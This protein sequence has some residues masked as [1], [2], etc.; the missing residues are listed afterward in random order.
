MRTLLII[1]AGISAFIG[2]IITILPFGTIGILPG[3]GAILLGL[4]AYL[5]SKKKQQPHKLSLVF[6]A[7][8]VLVTI[9]SGTKTLWVKDEIAVDKTFEKKEEQHKKEAIKELNELESE[10]EEIEE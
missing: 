8:G 3:V 7:I 6:M 5:V 9:G 10:L 1:L 2:L 4:V